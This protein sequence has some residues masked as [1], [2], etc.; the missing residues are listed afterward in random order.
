[1]SLRPRFILLVLALIIF[2]SPLVWWSVQS[3]TENIVNQWA[4]RYAEKQVQYDRVRSLQPILH[5]VALSHQ[6][7]ETPIMQRWAEHPNDPK[8]MRQGL[9][10]L[11]IYRHFFAEHTY[12]AA[13]RKNGAYYYNNESGEFTGH[14]L[15]Y[16]LKP[17]NPKDSWF[18]DLLRQPAHDVQIN[19]NEDAHLKVTKVWINVPVRLGNKVLGIVGTGL[20][21]TPFIK[22][23][24][25]SATPGI[26]TLFIDDDQGAIQLYRNQDLIDYAS[27]TKAKGE[28]KTID[29]L[30]HSRADRIAIHQAM[31]QAKQA[32]LNHVI[33]AFVDM[34]GRRSLLSVAYLPELHWYEV[35]LFDLAQVLPYRQFTLIAE[36]FLVILL[37]TLWSL[38]LAM[39]RWVIAPIQALTHDMDAV[40][41]GREPAHVQ[42]SVG[43]IGRLAHHFYHMTHVILSS[44]K[45]LEAKV[46]ER[47]EALEKLSKIDALTELLN[48]RGMT[49]RMELEWA[50]CQREGIKLALL[51]LDIDLFKQINDR[52]GHS[53][54][55]EALRNIGSMIRSVLRPYDA[56]ARWGG[57]EFL[58]MLVN[59]DEN[60]MNE[61]GVRIRDR[62]L[63]PDLLRTAT[64]E[65]VPIAVSIGGYVA[66]PGESLEEMLIKADKALYLAKARG[67][68]CYQNYSEG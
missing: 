60:A 15:R 43:E 53:M 50:R 52:Y 16:Y 66:R 6:L 31:K 46:A 1:M 23:S 64:G 54:G 38:Y 21:L 62:V 10:E 27:I 5:E 65:M 58:V 12:F 8:S 25:Q 59:A 57:D 37:V 45:E 36:V 26:S 41:L 51:W 42:K 28:H 7:A 19:V 2:S 67:R 13:F 11:E 48:R 24:V 29:L 4:V 22:R 17:S 14:E 33:T 3:V 40:E 32:K 56:A 47:T 30:F 44:N 63:Q 18:F 35:D 39:G 34:Q 20:D 9:A 55:D 68:N 49:E 61:I